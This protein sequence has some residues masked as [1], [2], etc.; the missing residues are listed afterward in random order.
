VVTGAGD[1]LVA[2]PLE[3]E[4]LVDPLLVDPLE[5][6]RLV[7]PLL[8]DPLELEPLELDPAAAAARFAEAV[9]LAVP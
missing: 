9:A 3:L 8:V 7:D 2:E 5:P 1:A 6:E 4:P